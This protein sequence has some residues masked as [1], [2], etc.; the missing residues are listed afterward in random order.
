MLRFSQ[1]SR[2]SMKYTDTSMRCGHETWVMDVGP[3]L[4][5]ILTAHIDCK[6][7][8]R[9]A[10]AWVKTIRNSMIGIRLTNM[11]NLATLYHPLAQIPSNAS[12][13][14]LHH[15]PKQAPSQSSIPSSLRRSVSDESVLSLDLVKLRGCQVIV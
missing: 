13:K 5:S 7:A 1:E 8:A 3:A 12:L 6:A 15:H 9:L 2:T 11:L 14:H 10:G 4:L